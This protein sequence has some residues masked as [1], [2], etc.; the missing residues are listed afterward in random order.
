MMSDSEEATLLEN[1]ANTNT[2]TAISRYYK[3]IHSKD[4]AV[5]VLVLVAIGAALFIMF[6]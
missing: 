3:K 6:H 5:G 1:R 2:T 4:V